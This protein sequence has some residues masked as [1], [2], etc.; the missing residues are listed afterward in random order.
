MKYLKQF[1][2]ILGVTC[3][4]E[5]LKYFISLPIPASV[6]GLIIMLV[7]LMTHTV[8]LDDVKEAGGFLVEIMPVMFIPA[9]AG[10]IVYWDQLRPVIIPILVTT[11]LTTVIVMGVTGKVTDFLLER[12]EKKNE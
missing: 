6:Y 7:L 3:V 10:L 2:V 9:G 4:G 11:L 12:K 8:K 5:I 1:A